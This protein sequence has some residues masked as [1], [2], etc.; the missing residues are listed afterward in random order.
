MET[1]LHIENEEFSF[2]FETYKKRYTWVQDMFVTEQDNI[3]H[4]EG[5]VGIHTN[6]VMDAMIALPEFKELSLEEK[7]IL[8]LG[9]LFLRLKV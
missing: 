3:H 8:F 6:M 5:N 9:S 2:D 1:P 7:K 4:S